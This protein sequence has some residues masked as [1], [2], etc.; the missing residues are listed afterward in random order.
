LALFLSCFLAQVFSER[1]H[2]ED[3]RVGCLAG[4]KSAWNYTQPLLW[5]QQCL[6]YSSCGW[7]FRQSPLNVP[8]LNNTG[9][10]P[11]PLKLNLQT[12]SVRLIR[13]GDYV[14]FPI[15]GNHTV[16]WRDIPT[17]GY[18]Q[19]NRIEFHSPSEHTL[20]GA[21]ADLEVQLYFNRTTHRG[22][23]YVAIAQLYD[24]G[25]CADPFLNKILPALPRVGSCT[26]GNNRTESFFP[27]LEQCDE[28][29]L[30]S[31]TVP[32]A[33]R[34]NCRLPYCGDN[35][36][37]AGEQC[38]NGR[39]NSANGTCRNCRLPVCGDGIIDTQLGEECDDRNNF[40]GDGCSGNCT[41]ECGDGCLQP[42]E[43]CDNGD[44]N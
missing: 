28:G 23:H 32:N 13:V 33:C 9:R 4:H 41:L 36:V 27:F 20:Q 11:A 17:D 30:N 5:G 19:L 12:E 24:I 6:H 18:Y 37:D 34:T 39:L 25:S 31:N 44:E 14:N 35:V 16:R 42:G 40:S 10:I 8:A 29:M 15:W 1:Y 38:D 3:P 21:R 26:C 2:H 22:T 43:E 7:G